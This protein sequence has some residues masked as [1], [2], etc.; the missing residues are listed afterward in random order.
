MSEDPAVSTARRTA[1]RRT[2]SHPPSSRFPAWRRQPCIVATTTASFTNTPEARALPS[3]GVTRLR[4]YI[5]PFPTPRWSA[6]PS[7]DVRGTRLLRPSRASPT[8]ADS[9]SGMLCSLPRW[10]DWCGRFLHGALPRRVLPSRL[11]LPRSCGGPASALPLSRPARALHVLRPARLLAH[12]SW[13][14]SRGSSPPGFQP[15][16]RQLSN[17]TI[18]YSSGSLPHW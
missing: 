10:P 15:A 16:A 11:G 4:R 18:N 1:H 17:L 6:V 9:L 12:L 8:D 14:M 3:P 13:T 2:G 7:D 5:W